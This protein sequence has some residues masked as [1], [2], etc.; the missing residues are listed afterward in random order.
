MRIYTVHLRR[1]LL[2]PER[3]L[4][5]VPEAFSWFAFLLPVVWALWHRLWLLAA[6]LLALELALGALLTQLDLA[7]LVAGVISLGLALLVGLLANDLRR[8]SLDRA[9]Y[10]EAAVVAGRDAS[11]AERRFFDLEPRLAV[12]ALR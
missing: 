11:E 9:G 7:P 5:L 6:A 3:D 8:L 12:E 10:I 1:P 4:Q 2:Q